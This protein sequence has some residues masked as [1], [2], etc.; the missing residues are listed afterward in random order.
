MRT[1]RIAT[2]VLRVV[3][4]YLPSSLIETIVFSELRGWHAGVP[5]SRFPDYLLLAPVLPLYVLDAIR[6]NSTTIERLSA[7]TFITTFVAIWVLQGLVI[8]RRHRHHIPKD[9]GDP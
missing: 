1:R 7:W 4:A 2:F 6:T 9:Q 3:A 8:G 5:L